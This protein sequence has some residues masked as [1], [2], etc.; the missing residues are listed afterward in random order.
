MK[1]L[2]RNEECDSDTFREDDVKDHLKSLGTPFFCYF[3]LANPTWAFFGD[4]HL[5]SD[6]IFLGFYLWAGYFVWMGFFY[7][8]IAPRRKVYCIK[9]GTEDWRSY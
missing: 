4:N 9:C 3:L 6:G 2:C 8:R 5:V 7:R 1:V